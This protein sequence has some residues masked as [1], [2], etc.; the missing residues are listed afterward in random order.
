ME[1][2]LST[3]MTLLIMV[4]MGG[5]AL[6]VTYYVSPTGN[7]GNPGTGE[8]PW[9][10]L[11]YAVDA[12]RP[13]DAVLVKSGTYDGCRI[14]RPGKPDAVCTLRADAGAKVLV[15]AAGPENRHRDNVEVEIEG[16]GRADRPCAEP[17]LPVQL[18]GQVRDPPGS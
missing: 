17:R 3:L 14:R 6:A 4:L 2:M 16:G 11:Q 9:R 10:T 13:G 12:V 7:S 8:K 15:N 1:K 5:V 18:A